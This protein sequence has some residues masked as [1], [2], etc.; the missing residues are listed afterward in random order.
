MAPRKTTTAGKAN[1][2]PRASAAPRSI[3]GTGYEAARLGRRLRGWVAERRNINAL[4]AAGGEQLRARARQLCREN[5]YAAAAAEAYTAAA[6]G[7]G[8]K[9]SSLI[10]DGDLK[11]AVQA[12]WLRW[13]DE[14][15]ADGVTDLYGIMAM[16][17]RAQFEAEMYSIAQICA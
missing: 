4:L 17:A 10:A 12:A 15:D 6:V 3:A 5:P 1:P 8:I 2:P 13:T 11:K 7:V 9:P 14:A 16:A